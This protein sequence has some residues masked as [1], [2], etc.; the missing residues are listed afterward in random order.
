ME[1]GYTYIDVKP[2]IPASNQTTA[3]IQGD[4]LFDWTEVRIPAGVGRLIGVSVLMR[5]VNGAAG[6]PPLDVYFSKSNT[7]SLGTPNSAVDMQPNNDLLGALSIT[8]GHY[9]SGLNHMEVANMTTSNRVTVPSIEIT[10]GP[11]TAGSH[12]IYIAGVAQTGFNFST[13]VETT[14]ILDVSGLSTAVTGTLDD[15]SGSSSLCLDKFAPGDIIHAEDDII[16]GEIASLTATTITFR[17]DGRK[18]YSNGGLVLYDTP[19]DLTAWKIQNGAGAAGDLADGD[20]LY[21]IHPIT[22][23]LSFAYGA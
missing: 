17:H 16:L 15:G 2:T 5:G 13:N 6:R 7:F 9:M 10:G 12:R 11:K 1:K 19:A 14:G 4:V 20:E 18:Q 23:K 21:N 3:F 8:Q 22:L